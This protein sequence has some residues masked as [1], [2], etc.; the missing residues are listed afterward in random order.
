MADQA[1]QVYGRILSGIVDSLDSRKSYDG[2]KD[3][4]FVLIN[5]PGSKLKDEVKISFK[6]HQSLQV[7]QELKMVVNRIEG[8]TG[9]TYF[10]AL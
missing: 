3:E 1:K 4:F 6:T 5:I 10:Q 8:K 2:S 9:K 7:G